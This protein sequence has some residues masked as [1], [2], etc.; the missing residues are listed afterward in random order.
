MILGPASGRERGRAGKL[1]L[2]K[3]DSRIPAD[4]QPRTCPRGQPINAF[5]RVSC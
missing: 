3:R 5:T 2:S 1:T 4:S